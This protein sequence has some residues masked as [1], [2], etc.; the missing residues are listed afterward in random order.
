MEILMGNDLKLTAE[1]GHELG[2]YRAD[3]DGAAKGGIVVLQEIFG[4]N[5]HIREVCDG[6]A[7]DGYVA[8]APALYDRS[9]KKNFQVGYVPEDIEAGRVLR[10]EFSWDDTVLDVKTAVDI[11]QGDGLKVGTVGY[12]WGGTI[13]YLAGVRLNV[14]GSIVYYGGQIEPYM[15]EAANCPMLMHF[16]EHDA[17]IPLAHVEDLR[18]AK[19]DADINIYDADHGFNCDHRGS[20]NE[21]S[22]KLAR[23]RT[24]AFFA[25]NLS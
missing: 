16:G 14:N 1:D 20:Y 17:G 4:V 7:A 8:I 10:D 19:P 15:N 24:M 12:C 22:A 6:F 3:P 18:K 11:L 13:S 23:E 25:A 2:A 9:S 21:A 5:S